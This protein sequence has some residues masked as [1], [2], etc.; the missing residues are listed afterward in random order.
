MTPPL[1]KRKLS[2]NLLPYPYF[3]PSK[4]VIDKVK[5]KLKERG[6]SKKK[7]LVFNPDPG[8][9][10]LR[11]WPI[12]NFASLAQGLLEK[13]EELEIVVSGT[14]SS[15]VYCEQLQS[16]LPAKSSSFLINF[17]GETSSL[18]ELSALFCLSQAVV[19]SDSG[20]AHIAAVSGA[21]TFV[22]FGPETPLR[23][24]PL[25][26]NVKVF[27]KGLHCSPCF[28]AFNHRQS[29]C[30]DNVCLKAITVKEVEKAVEKVL[31]V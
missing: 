23:Y 6:L 8:Q 10:R 25:G 29:P 15:K 28:S 27:F 12:K 5:L 1:V 13:F 18:S 26:K 17:C 24:K 9:L 16:L 31:Q 2:A 4:E 14:K 11:Q 22:L 19:T 30:L 7:F 20:A 3:K 21:N